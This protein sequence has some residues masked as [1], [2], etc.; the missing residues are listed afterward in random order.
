MRSFVSATSRF[1][2]GKFLLKARIDAMIFPL[3]FHSVIVA[4]ISKDVLGQDFVFCTEKRAVAR[5]NLVNF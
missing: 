3:L 4:E 1:F 5:L 2:P